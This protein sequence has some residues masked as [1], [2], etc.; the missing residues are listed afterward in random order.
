MTVA[1]ITY[2]AGRTLPRAVPREEIP[3]ASA[4]DQ[5]VIVVGG[6]RK[7][8]GFQFC[9]PAGPDTGPRAVLPGWRR[10]RAAAES[11]DAAKEA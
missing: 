7:R 5:S 4:G 11:G 3:V 1:M 9:V 8:S 10:W 2:T 6:R